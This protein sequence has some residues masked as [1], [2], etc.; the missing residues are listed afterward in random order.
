MSATGKIRMSADDH[1]DINRL[2]ISA[3]KINDSKASHKKPKLK[4]KGK[5]SP[6]RRHSA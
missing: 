1:A 4:A 5:S 3:A 2:K 6:E